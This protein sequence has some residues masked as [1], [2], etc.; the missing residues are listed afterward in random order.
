MKHKRGFAWLV[1]LGMTAGMFVLIALFGDVRFDANNDGSILRAFQ[2]YE[3]G[4]PATFHIFI[5]GLFSWPVGMLGRLIPGVN[6]Y[7]WAQLA[8]LFL[9][10]T[11]ITKSCIQICMQHAKSPWLGMALAFAFDVSFGVRHVTH[12]TFTVTSG[13]LGAAA[14]AQ[15]LSIPDMNKGVGRMVGAGMLAALAYALREE[16]LWPCLAI[17]GVAYLYLFFK[18]PKKPMLIS[19]MLVALILGGMI[20]TRE[21]EKTLNAEYADYLRWQ[22]ARYY[23]LDH[24]GLW[25]LTAEDRAMLG[26]SDATFEM[27]H[28]WNFLDADISTEKMEMLT[29]VLRERVRQVPM[30]DKFTNAWHLITG[31][32]TEWEEAIFL[33]AWLGVGLLSLLICRSCA[34]RLAV[35]AAIA[36]TIAML[37]YLGFDNRVTMHAA[38]L[39][40][41]AAVTLM[42]C[43]LAAHLPDGKR[44]MASAM[45]IAMFVLVFSF[46]TIQQMRP[47]AQ[48]TLAS[49]TVLD[50]LESYALLHSDDLI[51]YDHNFY[52]A[53]VRAF[54]EYPN[55]MPHNLISTGDWPMRSPQSVELFARFGIDLLQFD[56]AVF[57]RDDVYIAS[58]LDV[59]SEEIWNWLNEKLGGGVE[60]ELYSEW[61]SVYIFQFVQY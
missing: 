53:D 15:M 22:E 27:A 35:A 32:W 1:A 41:L 30:A 59:P 18:Q 17:C 25:Q 16:A 55:G 49:G 20:G 3:T 46:P 11:V 38:V 28:L 29:A 40:A 60:C 13:F 19:L 24:Y 58:I 45:A 33:L 4:V 51:L 44:G 21:L 12:F 31:L 37:F 9:S 6:W 5:H 39:P 52:A 2:G 14:V 36:L 26:W 42:M 47:P 57:L 43:M 34:A 23:P 54:P 61:G 8:L 7:S 50:D 56:P 48:Y 10:I